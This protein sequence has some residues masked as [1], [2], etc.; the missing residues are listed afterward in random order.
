MG[1]AADFIELVKKIYVEESPKVIIDAGS[2]DLAESI[3]M[4]EAFPEATILA[5]EPNPY[6]YKICYEASKNYTN[7]RV[8]EY[9]CGDIEDTVDFWLVNENVGASSILEPAEKFIN[10]GWQYGHRDCTFQKIPGIRVRRLDSFLQQIGIDKVDVIW[11]DV[12]GNELQALQ[13][14]GDYIKDVKVM[15]TEAAITPYYKGHQPKEVLEKWI[16]EQGF[17]TYFVPTRDPHM[18]GESD[19]ICIK[20]EIGLVYP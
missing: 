8:F 18:F 19:L 1:I 9:A 4:S 15:H 14:L 17:R 6:Q 5:F 11:M 2:R 10:A 12:Q 20:N 3:Q 7:I 13:G 16:Q